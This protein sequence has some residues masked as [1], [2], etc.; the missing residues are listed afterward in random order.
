MATLRELFGPGVEKVRFY[1]TQ[2]CMP[3]LSVVN[4]STAQDRT[5]DFQNY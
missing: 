1:S 2:L 4:S 3:K 5:K